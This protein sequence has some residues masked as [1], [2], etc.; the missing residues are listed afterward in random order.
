VGALAGYFA[1]LTTGGLF[2]NFEHRVEDFFKRMHFWGSQL[3]KVAKRFKVLLFPGML[4]EEMGFSYLGPVDGHDVHA[5][6]EIITN[7]KKLRGPVLLHVI[8][9][10]G[11]GYRPAENE[12]TRFH[13]IGRFNII[14]GESEAVKSGGFTQAFGHAMIKLAQ[15]DKSVVAITA[16]M[17]EG[18]GLADFAKEFPKRF[19]DV[20][21]AEGHALTF[22]AGL[23][24]DGI[25]P[26]CA[27]YST[28]LQRGI[29]QIIHDIALQ[30][31]PVVMAIDRAGL[32][33]E[34][35]ATHHG[36]FDMSYLRYIPGITIMAPADENE[37]QHMLFSALSI[38]GPSAIRYPRGS[39]GSTTTLDREFHSIPIGK[40]E[41]ISDGK[42]LYLLA[43]G[44]TVIPAI[45]AAAMLKAQGVSAGV[46]NMRFVK[47]LDGNL[48]KRLAKETGRLV[49]VE[50]NSCIGGLYGSVCELLA[51]S[52]ASILPIA[53]PD[54]F[55]EH[56]AQSLLRDKYGFSALKIASAIISW[57]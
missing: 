18:T 35:G 53:L 27:I 52:N 57:K 49:V 37:L 9:K 44:S 36:A 51:G 25:K 7:V 8:T 45:E 34:D 3:L 2:K 12:P 24:A 22:A 54:I 32:V 47:P 15:N 5:L 28:F 55:I 40:A 41:L 43:I 29:D 23:A 39:S 46:V 10:K 42:D 11:K 20:G 50:E 19:F 14:T 16:A 30:K 33:G 17:S 38:A 1:K 13:G 26:V 21:I 6:I 48:I 4:F 31:I 56:G